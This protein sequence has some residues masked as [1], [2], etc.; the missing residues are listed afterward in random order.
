MCQ[1]LRD[2]HQVPVRGAFNLPCTILPGSVAAGT[3]IPAMGKEV[4]IGI[5]GRQR[6]E[7]GSYRI[8]TILH[9]LRRLVARDSGGKR[10]CLVCQAVRSKWFRRLLLEARTRF[11]ARG[12]AAVRIQFLDSGMSGPAFR[13]LLLDMDIL[14]LP[15]DTGRYRYSGSG[16]IMDGVAAQIPIVHTRGMAMQELLVHGN[17]EA[18]GSDRE[19]A[20]KLLTVAKHLHGYRQG[21]RDACSHLEVLLEASAHRL[22]GEPPSAAG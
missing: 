4:R 12:D 9:H 19:F 8:P 2:H 22:V 7:K 6:A 5:L 17:A 18:A 10:I 16:L 15:Y 21:A 3:Q 1:R 13:Q 20:E 11:S 14:L